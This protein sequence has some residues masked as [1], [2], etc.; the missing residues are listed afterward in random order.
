MLQEL[1]HRKKNNRV[2]S[3]HFRQRQVTVCDQKI[4][5]MIEIA[6][7]TK[8]VTADNFKFS[9]FL[10]IT[11]ETGKQLWSPIKHCCHK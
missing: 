5:R 9:R 2:H 1:K 8:V 6:D 11:E 3:A 7:R 4:T 10:V